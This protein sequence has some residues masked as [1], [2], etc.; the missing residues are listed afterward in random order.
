MGAEQIGREKE[1]SQASAE[2]HHRLQVAKFKFELRLTLTTTEKGVER[3]H[4]FF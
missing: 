1:L 3:M 4:I 2:L